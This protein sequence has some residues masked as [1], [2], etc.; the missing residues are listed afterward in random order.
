[1]SCE[2]LNKMCEFLCGSVIPVQLVLLNTDIGVLSSL[3]EKKWVL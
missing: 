2:R 1:M 3:T